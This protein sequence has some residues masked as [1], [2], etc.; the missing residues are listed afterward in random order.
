MNLD[1]G[2]LLVLIGSAVALFPIV[3]AG[4][5]LALGIGEYLELRR[6]PLAEVRAVSETLGGLGFATNRIVPA[7]TEEARQLALVNAR[8]R[9]IWRATILALTIGAITLCFLLLR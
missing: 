7:G 2:P 9:V 3:L 8:S 4:V 6:R 1:L 5:W